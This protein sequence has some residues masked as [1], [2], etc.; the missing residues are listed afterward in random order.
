MML[1]Y[2]CFFHIFSLTIMPVAGSPDVSNSSA[3]GKGGAI[4]VYNDSIKNLKHFAYL[5]DSIG[6]KQLNQYITQLIR[7]NTNEAF[8]GFLQIRQSSEQ[9]GNL[10]LYTDATNQLGQWHYNQGNLDSALIYLEEAL[11]T[12]QTTRYTAGEAEALNYIGKYYHTKGEYTKS[13]QFYL[14][15]LKIAAGSK[16]S[17]RMAT[18]YTNIGKHYETLGNYHKA[19]ANYIESEKLLGAKNERII[20]GTIYDHLGSLYTIIRDYP[21]ALEYHLKSLDCRKTSNYRE[22]ISKSYKN[23]GQLYERTNTY[24]SALFYYRQALVLA[25]EVNYPKGIIKCLN[26]LANVSLQMG[27]FATAATY[28]GEALSLAQRT[29]Y[30]KGAANALL[31]L[32]RACYRRNLHGEAETY[33][34]KALGIA[35]SR[36]LKT[37]SMEVYKE[38]YLL[39]RSRGN[40]S[41]ALAWHIHYTDIQRELNNLDHARQFA[42]L[43]IAYETDKQTQTNKLLRAE[44]DLKSLQVRR[45]HTIIILTAIS[46]LLAIALVLVMYFRFSAK[47][48]SNQL[49]ARLNHKVMEQNQELHRLNKE[50]NQAVREKDKF[51]SIIAHELRNPLWWFRNLAEMLSLNFEHM[52]HAEIQ[53]TLQSLDESAKNAYH[54]SDNLLKWSRTKLNKLQ[55]QPTTLIL[56]EVTQSIVRQWATVAGYKHLKIHC[57][58]PESIRVYADK[59]QLETIVRNLLSNAL[60]YTPAGGIVTLTATSDSNMASLEIIDSGIGISPENIKRLFRDNKTYTTLGLMQ[61]KGTGLGLVL[62][63]EFI[64]LNGGRLFVNS[65]E[66][67]GTTFRFTIP[68]PEM[69]NPTTPALIIHPLE[70]QESCAL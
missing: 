25:R 48:K 60:K 54:L 22:G 23:I 67:Q 36:K 40:D 53:K 61:E 52:A 70:L 21:N 9:A 69:A 5:S 51:L 2:L 47:H 39:D 6:R 12:S 26:S 24:D 55:T 63:K 20:R 33:L 7:G 50:L 14:K 29:G 42:E 34:G 68:C 64:E 10:L 35:N 56:A 30:E 28:G 59:D 18:L 57:N 37:T 11:R 3:P 45:S 58:I 15:A 66:N 31:T 1:I 49:L 38:L 16:D 46:L 13:N 19:M 62:C 44:N 17:L 4:W 65:I 41:L 43:K 27:N 8:A 32:G